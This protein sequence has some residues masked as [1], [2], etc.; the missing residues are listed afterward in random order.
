MGTIKKIF[1]DTP[2]GNITVTFVEECHHL[3]KPY[4]SL[5][6]VKYSIVHK[7]PLDIDNIKELFEKTKEFLDWYEEGVDEIE[8]EESC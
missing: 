7:I 4:E 1:Y 3:V 5:E 6:E 8:K 2:S